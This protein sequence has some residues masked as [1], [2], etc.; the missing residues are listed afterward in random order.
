VET[1]PANTEPEEMQTLF[2]NK[3][4]PKLWKISLDR[5]IRDCVHVPAVEADVNI[6][7]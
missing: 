1:H 2:G 5:R 3:W 7:V 4:R 6:T